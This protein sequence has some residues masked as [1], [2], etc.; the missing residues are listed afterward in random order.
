MEL[1]SGNILASNADA[2]VNTVNCIGY[3]GKGIALQFK[4]AYPT[5]FL[6]YHKYCTQGKLSPGTML[7]YETG[8][9][10]GPR[11]II[12]FPTKKH[13]RETSHYEY[14]Q[15]GLND[16]VDVIREKNIRSIAI[17][18]LGCGNGGLD[19]K[20]VRPMIEKA[21][22]PL[23]EVHV[24]IYEPIGAPDPASMPIGT[25]RPRLT[26]ARA[27]LIA[28][29][30]AYSQGA[31]RLTLLEIHKLAYFL[32]E[33]GQPLKLK[34]D[35]GHYGPYAPNLNKVLEVLEGHFTRGYGDSQAPDV[36]INLLPGAREEAQQ[37][38]KDATEESKH[39]RSVGALI[40]GF[41]SP[42]G[43]ELLASAH[44][45]A[46]YEAPCVLDL[47]GACKGFA[48]WNERKRT[49]FKPEHIR[50]AWDRL[51]EHR[52]ITVSAD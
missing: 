38:L 20:K 44:W 39:L 24:E 11:F 16:L 15:Q 49:I 2:L 26:S 43:M 52:W 22:Q 32:Q 4:K 8:A 9:M 48:Q 30:D 3:M 13:W 42:Y 27:L 10:V 7:V 23:H 47:N 46:K 37:F 21:M 41:E 51:I 45:L 18:P 6:V 28:L 1:L 50:I 17:P 34:Y 36:D 12:N 35:K 33:A 5:N 19:W 14:I 29:M 25:V 31:Y 40:E